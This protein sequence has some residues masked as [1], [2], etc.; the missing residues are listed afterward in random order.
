MFQFTKN[1]RQAWVDVFRQ[2]VWVVMWVI[3]LCW[4][5][6]FYL[7]M[8]VEVSLIKHHLI[9]AAPS[10]LPPLSSPWEFA[11]FSYGWHIPRGW[12]KVVISPAVGT[13]VEG[14]CPTS[15]A[16]VNLWPD[17]RCAKLNVFSSYT[18]HSSWSEI[19]KPLTKNC[20]FWN[21]LKWIKCSLLQNAVVY[22]CPHYLLWD[23]GF[24]G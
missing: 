6:K 19:Y 5:Y 4:S 18:C 20:H 9:P 21:H 1:S 14:R 16:P 2:F 12:G 24:L 10:P 23:Y 3:L 15:K 17:V 7:S 11:F 8:S 22:T 13:K